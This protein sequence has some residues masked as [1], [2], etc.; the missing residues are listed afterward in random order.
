LKSIG[1]TVD[2]QRK[3]FITCHSL[4]HTFITLARL[5]DIPDVVIMALA[6]QKSEKVM[7]KYSHVPQVIDFNDAREKLEKNGVKEQKPANKAE[8]AKAA[9]G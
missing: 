2:Q 9:N 3:R 8:E 5:S 4:R 7:R 6:G 1:I